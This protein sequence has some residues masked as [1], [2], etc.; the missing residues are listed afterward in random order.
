MVPRLH[1]SPRGGRRE[2]PRNGRR[3][4]AIRPKVPPT[5]RQ[6]NPPGR[7]I[8]PKVPPRTPLARITTEAAS[9]GRRLESAI[10]ILITCSAFALGP[11][12]GARRMVLARRRERPPGGA[13]RPK[14]PPT[15]RQGNPPGRAIGPKVP[16]RTPLARITTEAASSGR[17]LESAIGILITCS[18]FALGPAMGARRMVLARRRERPP[19]GAIR[20]KVRPSSSPTLLARITTEAASSGRRLESAIGILITC[21]AFALGPAMGARRMVLARRR[22]RPPGGAIRPKVR[23][24]SSPTLLARITTEAASSGRRLESAIGIL[25]TCSAFALGPAIL[26]RR[27]FQLYSSYV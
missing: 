13:I 19:G 9:S 14:V 8:G 10:G 18:A 25:I 21:S 6:G 27:S 22:E 15:G 23:P 1:G 2:G 7:A 24:S 20:P 12:M 26:A 5:G 16:P 11:A 3:E 17:R 4:G